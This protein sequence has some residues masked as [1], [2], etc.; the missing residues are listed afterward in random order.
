M[1][2]TLIN[3]PSPYLTNDAAYPPMGL[4]YLA[5]SLIIQGHEVKVVDLTGGIDWKKEIMKQHADL[6]GITCVTPNF[7]IVSEIAEVLNNTIVIGGPH[8]TFLP[9]ETLEKVSCNTIVIGEGEV[10]IQELTRDLERGCLE[11][12]YRGGM[13][14]VEA[15]PKP[16]RHLVDLHR[17][18]PG[19]EDATTI[20]TSRGCSYNCN[21]CSKITG[22]IYREFPISRV[23]EEIEEVI[24]MGF[25]K[26]VF[27]DDNII[28]DPMRVRRLLR[29]IKPLNIEFRLNQD[30][31]CV[32][33][34]LIALA[35]SSGCTEISYGIEHGSQK[36]L[37]LMNKHTTVEANKDVILATKKHGLTAKAYFIVNFPG[38]DDETVNETL[39][40]AAEVMPDRWLLSSFAPL[41][42]CDVFR[43]PEKYGITWL[44]K[45]WEDYYLVGKGGGFKPCFTTKTLSVEKQI[46]LHDMMYRGLKEIL[47]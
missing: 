6:F 22:R 4:L 27:G 31:R 7:S 38:E 46:Y 47:G 12:I 39:K 44:S 17:Y 9:E 40:F 18:R 19:G 43:N 24:S 2:V 8:P 1:K 11:S 41:P 33:E 23:V 16:A 32:R 13:V 34:D 37:D 28:I 25:R 14:P 15:I 5:A 42:G 10:A 21:F 35:A 20:Y 26:I 36:I 29:A 3:P 30:A 45:N